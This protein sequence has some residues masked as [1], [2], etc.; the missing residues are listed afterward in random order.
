MRNKP[1]FYDIEFLDMV[2]NEMM[3][4]SNLDTQF[5][6]N[7]LELAETDDETYELIVKWIRCSSTLEQKYFEEQMANILLKYGLL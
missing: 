4:Y 3:D 2:Y 5:I 1:D 6:S 7:I